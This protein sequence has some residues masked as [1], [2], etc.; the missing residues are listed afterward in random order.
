MSSICKIPTKNTNLIITDLD[1]EH[2]NHHNIS[3]NNIEY[4]HNERD[5]LSYF[6]AIG[7]PSY[8]VSELFDLNRQDPTEPN[9]HSNTLTYPKQIRNKMR[10]IPTLPTQKFTGINKINN[11]FKVFDE[12]KKLVGFY[13]KMKR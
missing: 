6:K 10:D 13:F 3:F 5:M 7:S 11:I 2:L 9:F 8:K 4:S 1:N 12:R